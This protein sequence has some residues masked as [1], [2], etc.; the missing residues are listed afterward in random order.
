MDINM[1]IGIIG[2]AVLLAMIFL[3]VWVGF[4]LIIAGFVGLW[5]LR[6]FNF[7]L[8]VIGNDPYTQAT[9]YAMTCMPL[10]TMMGTVISY[11]GLGAKLYRW[12]RSLIGHV[13]GGLGMAT[14]GACAIFAAICG[15]SQVT[16]LTLGRIAYPEMRKAGYSEEIAAG[17]IAAGGGIGTMIPPSLGFMVYGLLT[18]QSIGKLF[19]CGLIPGICMALMYCAVYYIV[20]RIRPD[21][22]PTSTWKGW[23]EVGEATKDVWSIVLLMAIMLG[24]IY[25]GIFTATE[26][27]A[28]GAVGSILI[29]L[30]TKKLTLK[31]LY[32]A[33]LDGTRTC[34]MVMILL[35]GAKVFLRFITLTGLTDAISSFIL[36]LSVP[37]WTILALVIL[38]YLILGS[39]FDIMSAILLTVPFLYP[40]MVELGFNP[41]WFG[42]FVVAMMEMGDLTPPIGLSLFVIS[43]AFKLPTKTVIKGVLPFIVCQFFFILLICFIPKLTLLLV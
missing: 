16:A 31:I 15:N 25:G 28:V 36:G 42:V 17:G 14:V 24:G 20:A 11:T 30:S 32:R 43:E 35:I 33:L 18:E 29:A 2:F 4:A 23:R 12:M 3:R 37:R 9:Q 27:G 41:M 22:A 5:V 10:F 26:A 1:L 40:I 21:A 38:L 8:N 6:D 34:G 7:A 13:R 19:M 39:A